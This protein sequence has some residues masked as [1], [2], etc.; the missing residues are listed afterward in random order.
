MCSSCHFKII[1]RILIFAMLHLCWLNSYG[2]AEMVPMESSFEQPSQD[3]TDR[4]RILDLMNRR[5]VVDEFEK[6]GISKMEATARINSLTDE[7]VTQIAGKLDGLPAAG[8]FLP[9]FLVS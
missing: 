3:E 1:S 9:W 5:E 6:Y 7:E 8:F 4:Q 2:Y